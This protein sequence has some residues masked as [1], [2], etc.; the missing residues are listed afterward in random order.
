MRSVGV[1]QAVRSQ[2]AP[3]RFVDV[4]SRQ[5]LHAIGNGR[6]LQPHARAA[7]IRLP[8]VIDLHQVPAAGAG[9]RGVLSVRSSGV[10]GEGGEQKRGGHE[11]CFLRKGRDGR[12]FGSRRTARS[13]VHRAV[14]VM[15]LPTYCY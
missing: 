5:P 14:V 3:G 4:G 6:Y 1:V 12:A 7:G 8:Q 2:F 15:G 13:M 11:D 10:G 9:G